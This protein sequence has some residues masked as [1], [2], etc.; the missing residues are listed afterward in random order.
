MTFTPGI[1]ESKTLLTLSGHTG[2]VEAI[3][4]SPDGARLATGGDGLVRVYALRIEDLI[5][6]AKK[7]ATRSLTIAECQQYLH[8]TVCPAE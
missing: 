5:A 2:A 6:L 1:S 4:F 7:R 8:L 3:A